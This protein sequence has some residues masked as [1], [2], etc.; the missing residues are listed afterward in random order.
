MIILRSIA[1]LEL[2]MALFMAY[3]V[4]QLTLQAYHAHQLHPQI[5]FI[6]SNVNLVVLGFLFLFILLSASAGYFLLKNKK[7]GYVLSIIAQVCQ[8]FYISFPGF[9]YS[10]FFGIYWLIYL[11]PGA[12]IYNVI[13]TFGAGYLFFQNDPVIANSIGLG[14]NVIPLV[15]MVY[16][17]KKLS[18][19]RLTEKSVLDH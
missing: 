11:E 6:I 7:T 16:L 4:S 15:L 9:I 3:F 19:L 2:L 14:I 13:S 8:I 18:K 17:L 5:T 1:I 12:G 10:N